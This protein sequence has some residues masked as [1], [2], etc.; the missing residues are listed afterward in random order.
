MS[1][2]HTKEQALN[3]LAYKLRVTANAR[4]FK[5]DILSATPNRIGF[6][7]CCLCGKDECDC[8]KIENNLRVEYVR[9]LLEIDPSLI[10]LTRG[11]LMPA[12][13]LCE[14]C[15]ICEELIDNPEDCPRHDAPY[16]VECYHSFSRG[17]GQFVARACAGKFDDVTFAEYNLK[18]GVD[19]W[20]VYELYNSIDSSV[21]DSIRKI[22]VGYYHIKL[23]DGTNLMGESDDIVSLVHGAFAR[24]QGIQGHRLFKAGPCRGSK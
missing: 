20:A 5:D 7:A 14:D 1:D 15:R 9:T 13:K 4:T 17:M 18:R 21:R 6:S 24:Q 2:Q 10:Q 3:E 19:V 16:K 23:A 8:D 11:E 12:D 22:V